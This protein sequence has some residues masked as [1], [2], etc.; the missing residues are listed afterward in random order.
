MMDTVLVTGGS[1]TLGQHVLRT[2]A[3][4]VRV[5]AVMHQRSVEIP[6]AEIELLHGG[7]FAT[8]RHFKK[9]R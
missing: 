2:L 7:L 5:L 3:S 9:L 6:G 8:R 4:Q 1:S